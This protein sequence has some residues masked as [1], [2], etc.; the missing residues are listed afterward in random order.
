M[1]RLF[2]ALAAAV[3]FLPCAAKAHATNWHLAVEPLFGMKWGQIDEYV[4]LKDSDYSNDKLSEL[5]WEIKPLFY[6]GVRVSGGW[7]GI[8]V[9]TSFTGAIPARTGITYDSDWQNIRYKNTGD[10]QYKTNYS[11]SDNELDSNIT[12]SI[13]GG[14]TFA[15]VSFFSIKPFVGFDYDHI[16]FT[17]YDGNYWYGASASNHLYAYD[18]TEAEHRETGTFSGKVLGYERQ[19]YFVWLG[20]SMA[21]FFP[22]NLSCT[23]GAQVAPYLYTFST[24]THYLTN[25][26]E[27]VDIVEGYF[28]AFKAFSSIR[29]ACTNRFS[30][31]IN[32]EFFYMKILRGDDYTKTAN[33]SSYTLSTYV[34]GGAGASFFDLAVSCKFRIF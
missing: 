1:K 23:L 7:R 27:Y 26:T 34:D 31:C 4:F 13:N 20:L 32:G 11:E 2:I 9:S 18:D 24:D 10:Y 29:Y 28:S 15:P 8:E 30:V 21:F 3:F 14:Y 22:Y 12:W 17:A 19:S 5:N 25:S 33:A 6:L 16:A